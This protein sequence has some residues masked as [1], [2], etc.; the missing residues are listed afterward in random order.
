[1]D[2]EKFDAEEVGTEVA[3]VFDGVALELAGTY[4]E[5][6]GMRGRPDE[7]GLSAVFFFVDDV[8]GAG[9]VEVDVDGWGGGVVVDRN[10]FVRAVVNRDDAEGRIGQEGLVVLRKRTR[11]SDARS[12]TKDQERKE[13]ERVVHCVKTFGEC[14]LVAGDFGVDGAGP[15]VDAASERLGVAKALFAKPEGNVEGAGSVV[16]HDDDWGVGVELGV[17]AGGD[18]AHGHED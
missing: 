12:D 13:A 8:D 4:A 14:D 6:S 5:G 1:M 17:G 9:V 7:G 2:V 18:V 3:W 10:F 16:A 15:G 11:L